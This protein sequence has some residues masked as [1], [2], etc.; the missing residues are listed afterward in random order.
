MKYK[1]ENVSI[2]MVKEPPLLCDNPVNSPGRAV[3][4]LFDL[5]HDYDREL[6]IVVN[7]KTDMTPINMSIV[8]MGTVNASLASSREMLKTS[9]LSNAAAVMIFHNH[10]SGRVYPSEADIRLT[11]KLIQ[12]YS[13][14]DIAVL[15]HIVLGPNRDY[16]SFRENSKLNLDVDHYDEKIEHLR[17]A[18]K[19][20]EHKERSPEEKER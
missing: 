18:D 20:P 15:D 2:R 7:L 19:S 4:V 9:I 1:L 14:M 8:S 11:D 10:P 6:M 3:E 16:F 17:F 5:L 13:V 12:A